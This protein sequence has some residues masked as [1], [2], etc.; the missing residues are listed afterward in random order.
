MGVDGFST[1][2]RASLEQLSMCASDPLRGT[3]SFRWT[4]IIAAREIW[5]VPLAIRSRIA[6]LPLKIHVARSHGTA[7]LWIFQ[8]AERQFSW[9]T[10]GI[11]CVPFNA[12]QAFPARFLLLCFRIHISFPGNEFSLVV[13]D[14][15]R[16]DGILI[17]CF[18]LKLW[19]CV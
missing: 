6:F 9:G 7:M 8:F 4:R 15:D 1:T 16:T 11:Q 2:I 5:H 17:R 3:Q 12:I 14:F 10:V 18:W 19:E 13:N